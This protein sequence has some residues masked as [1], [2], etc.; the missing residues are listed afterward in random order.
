MSLDL[1]FDY[2]FSPAF[3]HGALL[4]LVITVTSLFFGMITG[5]IVALLQESRIKPLQ[6]GTLVYLWLFRGTP[7]LFQIIFIYN[8]LPTFG[9]MLSAFVSAIIALSLNEGAYMA[10]IIRSGLQAVKKGQRTA[11]LALG[12]SRFAVMRYIVIPQAARIVLPPTGNQMIGM[13]KTSALVSVVAVEE[14]LLVA[15]QTASSN[16][17]YFEALTAAG[18]YYLVLTTIFMG[19]QYLLE[20][21]LDRKRP[22]EKRRSVPLMARLTALTEKTEAR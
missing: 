4:T 22:R 8:V 5:L 15:N 21:A 16:F 9:I 18:I 10:E 20:R 17:K 14:L 3:F 7:V 11:G 6:I 19:L 13:L 2:V 12:M 1:V